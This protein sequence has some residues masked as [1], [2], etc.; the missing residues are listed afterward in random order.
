VCGS[1]AHS[2]TAC[3][4]FLPPHGPSKLD[5]VLMAGLARHVALLPVVGKADC[6]SGAEAEE[7]CRLVTHVMQQPGEYVAGLEAVEL[8]R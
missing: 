1:L 5:L 8:Y 2:V 6:M 3:L 4:Y 7:C